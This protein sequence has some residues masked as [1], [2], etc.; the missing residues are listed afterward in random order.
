M[1]EE[2]TIGTERGITMEEW[3]A[4]QRN[5]QIQSANVTSKYQYGKKKKVFHI[6]IFLFTKD[7]R[8][9]VFSDRVLQEII[10]NRP[11]PLN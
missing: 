2:K 3:N 9:L 4:R 11:T 8:S 1:K 7:Q 6:F 5:Q 10:F